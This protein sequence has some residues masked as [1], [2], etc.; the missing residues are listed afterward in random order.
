MEASGLLPHLSANTTAMAPFLHQ[1]LA[2]LGRDGAAVTTWPALALSARTVVGSLLAIV[3]AA[4]A[5]AAGIGGGGLFIPLFNFVLLFDTKSSAIMSIAVVCGGA[6]VA[7]AVNAQRKHPTTPAAPLI[8]YDIALL[9]QP[10]VLLGTTLG[11][12]GNV[13]S[14]TWLIVI[15]LIA[16]LGYSGYRSVNG[17][18][19]AWNKETAERAK[20]KEVAEVD[21]SQALEAG[22]AGEATTD[23]VPSVQQP[24]LDAPASEAKG[25]AIPLKKV[26]ALLVVWLV[27][28][29]LQLLRDSQRTCSALYWVLDA[30]QIPVAVLITFYMARGIRA[31]EATS[32]STASQLAGRP[33]TLYPLMLL[34][35]VMGAFV[36]LGGGM[37]INPVFLELGVNAQVTAATGNF[38]VLFLASSS[39]V[40][41][42][43]L[44]KVPVYYALYFM[45]LCAVGSLAGLKLVRGVVQR[46][47]RASIIVLLLGGII[48]A[49]AILMVIVGS[50]DVLKEY[51]SGASMGFHSL[52]SS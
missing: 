7:F 17:G 5:N 46:S 12:I 40:Q 24:L 26:L 52:C 23:G 31:S 33:L 18:V 43:L 25:P 48:S 47:G 39:F 15:I 21:A 41:Y 34:V 1:A 27:F 9:C 4:L 38:M 8:D 42:I 28:F 35:G 3:G 30:V 2:L 22:A 29:A 50:L 16:T 49:S 20:A 19:K 32:G 13:A 6:V 14:P 37:L 11:V 10:A 44:K 51:H 45:L 36:G